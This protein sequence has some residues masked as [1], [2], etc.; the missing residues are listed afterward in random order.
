MP[1]CGAIGSTPPVIW[2]CQKSNL[3]I[4]GRKFH[5]LRNWGVPVALLHGTS[6]DLLEPS[7]VSGYFLHGKGTTPAHKVKAHTYIKQCTAWQENK[8]PRLQM[9]CGYGDISS[10]C[11]EIRSC[12]PCVSMTAADLFLPQASII[13]KTIILSNKKVN[14]N[15]ALCHLL[16]FYVGF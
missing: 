3:D 12:T 6:V 2:L 9:V 5:H 7:T 8:K 15:T 4:W 16:M 1:F 13:Q 11:E 10:G 14:S